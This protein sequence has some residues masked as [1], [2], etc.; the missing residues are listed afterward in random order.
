MDCNAQEALQF[1]KPWSVS[2]KASYKAVL[3]LADRPSTPWSCID[4]PDKPGNPKKTLTST[5]TPSEGSS[6]RAPQTRNL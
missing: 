5:P 3:P 1:S 2:K 4:Y 6:S